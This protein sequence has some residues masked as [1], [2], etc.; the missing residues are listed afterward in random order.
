[1]RRPRQ[2]GR[3]WLVGGVTIAAAL[4]L[5]YVLTSLTGIIS[6]YRFPSPPEFLA[7]LR[8]IAVDG[9]AGGTLLQQTLQSLKIVIEGF[10]VA[11]LVGVPLGFLMGWSPR[12]E[13]LLNPVFLLIRPI[14]PLAWIPLAIV[15][16]GLGDGA[17]IMV[18]WFAAFVPSAINTFTGV[19]QINPIL[20]EAARVHGATDWRVAKEVIAP[21]ALP[22]IFTGLRLSLQA[23]WT[24]LVAA[25]LVGAFLGLGRVLSI[26]YRDIYPAMIAVA[27]VTIAIAG[28]LMTQLLA[29]IEQMVIRWR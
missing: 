16:L 4:L 29:R 26:A 19:R 5:W 17:K 22:M 1:M 10:L 15:W 25:E 7:A 11:S 21:G 28:A 6:S 13:A 23:S 20:I 27:M 3:G 18:I 24:T 14:P 2:V 12:T 9:Y 8:Q